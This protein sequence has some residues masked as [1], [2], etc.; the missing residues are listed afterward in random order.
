MPL[1]APV[2]SP[3]VAAIT[4]A[5]VEGLCTNCDH[6]LGEPRPRFCPSCGQETNIK[7]PT[8]GE[9]AQQF[10]GTYFASEGALW[11][12]IKMLLTRPG[13]LT[14]QYLNGRRKHYVLPL[15][16]F[17]SISLVMLLTMRIVGAL[18]FSTLD[19]PEFTKTLPDRPSA[20]ALELGFARAGIEEGAFFCEG[21][22]AWLC[23]RL[24]RRMDTST[25]ALLASIEKA[26]DR[27]ASNAGLVMFV[28]L[29]A[30][31]LGLAFF[32]RWRGFSFTEHLVFA[33]HLHAF[34]F[35]VVAVM[36]LGIEWLVVLG[37][38]VIPAYA[39]LAF[40]RV[41]GGPPL[42]LAVRVLLLTVVHGTLLAATAAL[43]ALAALLL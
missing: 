19:D 26:S 20:I 12:T 1:L 41:Y 39:A 5:A 2:P 33:L 32:F 15:R 13:E 11:R 22:P 36:M 14:A 35:L 8:V 29:P 23:K 43:V 25:V 42:R 24:Q 28:L 9:F 7:A 16:L 17:L 27:V 4:L 37:L 30:F 40:R 10:S 6:P 18:Q 31:A 34:W 3:E 21:L 38:I